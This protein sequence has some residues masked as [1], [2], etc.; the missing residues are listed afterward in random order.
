MEDELRTANL[1]LESKNQLKSELA[2][3]V[4][5]QLST[6]LAALKNTVSDAKANTPDKISPKLKQN[7]DSADESIDCLTEIINDFIRISEQNYCPQDKLEVD[8]A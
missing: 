5:E 4:S 6:L 3:A 8:R 7:L 2:I 1:K